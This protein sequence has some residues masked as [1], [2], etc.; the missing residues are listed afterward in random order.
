LP[1]GQAKGEVITA[2]G[3]TPESV[4]VGLTIRI[5]RRVSRSSGAAAARIA[6]FL[7][8]EGREYFR[9]TAIFA[10]TIASSPGGRAR[11]REIISRNAKASSINN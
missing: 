7:G 5:F 4:R 10:A 6:E 9:Q 8:T 3:A 2:T 1:W 11:M